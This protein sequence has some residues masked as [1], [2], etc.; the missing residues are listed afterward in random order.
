MKNDGAAAAGPS[1]PGKAGGGTPA[2]QRIEVKETKEVQVRDSG[3]TL[4]GCHSERSEE[5]GFAEGE[6]RS[7]RWQDQILR[8]RRTARPQNDMIREA[9]LKTDSFSVS[10]VAN[11]F[12]DAELT[13]SHA[14]K[15]FARKELA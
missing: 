8:P 2:L 15:S 3:A 1:R 14:K 7:C 4:N 9:P 12:T 11:C 10:S 5:S 13:T 6:T